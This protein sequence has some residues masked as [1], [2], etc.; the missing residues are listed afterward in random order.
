METQDDV[1]QRARTSRQRL[2]VQFNT[3]APLHPSTS[4]NLS[5]FIVAPRTPEITRSA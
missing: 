5:S 3:L 4:D 1:A 2:S